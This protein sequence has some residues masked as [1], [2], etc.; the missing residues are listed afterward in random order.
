MRVLITEWSWRTKLTLAGQPSS[1]AEWSD[2]NKLLVPSQ[3]SLTHYYYRTAATQFI[4]T[5][6]GFTVRSEISTEPELRLK[7]TANRSIFFAYLSIRFLRMISLS[8]SL[9]SWLHARWTMLT[10]WDWRGRIIFSSTTCEYW[11]VLLVT[12]EFWLN[13]SV[14]L[15]VLLVSVMSGCLREYKWMFSPDCDWLWCGVVWLCCTLLLCCSAGCQLSP[16]RGAAGHS[17]LPALLHHDI[18]SS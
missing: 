1:P 18:I 2:N 5:S 15:G 11:K 14:W 7:Q 6:P 3:P 9:S 4:T 8:L 12:S 16:A 10:V 17:Q 13:I